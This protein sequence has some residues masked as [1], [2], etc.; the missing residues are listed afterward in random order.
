MV[1]GDKIELKV[2][3]ND[4]VI[5]VGVN[6]MYRKGDSWIAGETMEVLTEKFVSELS[7]WTDQKVAK[8]HVLKYVNGAFYLLGFTISDSESISPKATNLKL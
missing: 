4:Q 1:F 3:E 2:S 8:C 5:Q 7:L 6:T